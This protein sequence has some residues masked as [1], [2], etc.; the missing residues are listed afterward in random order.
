MEQGKT[1]TKTM[2][3]TMTPDIITDAYAKEEKWGHEI[4]IN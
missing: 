3:K 4:N 1:T 2:I